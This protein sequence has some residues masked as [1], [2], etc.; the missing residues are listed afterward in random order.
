MMYWDPKMSRWSST[1]L[2]PTVVIPGYEPPGPNLREAH[3]QVLKHKL[4]LVI[5]IQ[6][7]PVEV[8]VRELR[9]G[10]LRPRPVN[11][12]ISNTLEPGFHPSEDSVHVLLFLGVVAPVLP[13]GE[14]WLEGPGIDEM[15]PFR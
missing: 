7:D 2:P 3:G 10:L 13:S 1:F 14:F 15:E 5:A 8:A 6:V 9:H 11:G 12:D 4:E